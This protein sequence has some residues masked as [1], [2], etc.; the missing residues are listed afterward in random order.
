[1]VVADEILPVQSIS[2]D[3]DIV[4]VVDL[5]HSLCKIDTLHEALITMALRAPVQTLMLAANPRRSKSQF[6]RTVADHVVLRPETLPYNQ[7]VL[8]ALREARKNGRRTALVSASDQR[9]VTAI[10]EHLGLFD[11]ALGTGGTPMTETNLGGRAKADAL[12]ERYGEKGFDYIGDAA[13][14][15]EVWQR[16]RLSY[17]VG[18]SPSLRRSAA[19]RGIEVIELEPARDSLDRLRVHLKA[20]RPHQ[21]SKNLLLFLPMLASHDFSQFLVVCTAFVCFCLTAS[22]VYI[23][24]DVIDL[25]SDRVHERKRMRPFATGELSSRRGVIMAAG[26]L[27]SAAGLS[28]AFT[29]PNLVAVLAMYFVATLAYSTWLKRK[30]LVDVIALAGL[31]TIRII[32]GGVAAQAV[33]SHWLLAFSMFLFFSLATMKRQTELSAQA[34]DGKAPGRG[35]YSDDLSVIRSMAISSGHAAILVLALYVADPATR[36]LYAAPQVIWLICPLLF[37][38]L[39]RMQV[40]THRGFMDDDPIVF[41]MRDRISLAVGVLAAVIVLIAYWGW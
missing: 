13:S 31:Y 28:A 23:I 21:W 16:A 24:N 12:A 25:P 20:L 37:Y 15:L 22:A 41:A 4:L 3:T 14:D 1:M 32:A 10:A 19:K 29:T 38:W 17:G 9:Q 39:G 7:N 30:L 40:L 5:D 27:L 6:K 36:E 35:Y 34:R 11:E 18:I 33:L 8:E 2:A 26:L